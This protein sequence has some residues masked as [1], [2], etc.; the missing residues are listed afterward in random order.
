MS[1]K[2]KWALIALAFMTCGLLLPLLFPK[3]KR[4]GGR[5]P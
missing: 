5:R 4:K 2:A 1:P 3:D